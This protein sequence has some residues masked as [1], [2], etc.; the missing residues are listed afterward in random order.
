MGSNLA[1]KE[2]KEASSKKKGSKNNVAK[3]PKRI[4]P[5]LSPEEIE[6]TILENYE[7][8]SRMAWKLLSNWRVRMPEDEVMS[9]V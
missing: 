7:H 5:K 8:A 1:Y 3:L 9:V 2:E 6:S 4:I